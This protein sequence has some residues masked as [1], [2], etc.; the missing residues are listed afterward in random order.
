LINIAARQSSLSCLSLRGCFTILL[1]VLLGKF[2]KQLQLCMRKHVMNMLIG[3]AGQAVGAFCSHS[4]SQKAEIL[5]YLERKQGT[6]SRVLNK[7]ASSNN[8][9][10]RS[11]DW[12][13]SGSPTQS[14]VVLT[15]KSSCPVFACAAGNSIS[16]GKDGRAPSVLSICGQLEQ[17]ST[18]ILPQQKFDCS[19][20]TAAAAPAGDG[21]PPVLKDSSHHHH[22]PAPNRH[23]TPLRETISA[24][25]SLAGTVRQQLAGNILY[26]S[27]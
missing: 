12:R 15:A 5:N 13:H 26:I 9:S 1:T 27:L 17:P 24:R 8:I 20:T 6:I 16:R 14:P 11:E 2:L 3:C 10:M 25:L 22:Y 7:E 18:S 19:L 4:I 23:T 21:G